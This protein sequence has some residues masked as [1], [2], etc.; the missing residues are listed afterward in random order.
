VADH[1]HLLTTCQ[2]AAGQ[3]GDDHRL[4]GAGWGHHAG[5]LPVEHGCIAGISQAGLVVAELKGHGVAMV[6]GCN[7]LEQHY[8][9]PTQARSVPLHVMVKPSH[10]ATLDWI[11]ATT[12][13]IES[14]SQAVR[15]LIEQADKALAAQA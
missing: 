11:A 1:H 15:M 8:R 7:D 3:L 9:M 14:R 10:M 5:P 4:A 13:G 6:I 2:C 12:P